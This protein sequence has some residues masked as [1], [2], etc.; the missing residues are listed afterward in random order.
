MTMPQKLS[1]GDWVNAGLKALAR[2]GFTAVKA[3]QIA[4]RLTVSRGSFYWHFADTAAFQKAVMQRWRDV[5]AESVIRDLE[6][7][8]TASER[9]PHLLRV[10]FD[11]DTA[12]EIAMRAWASSDTRARALVRSV[13]DRRLAYLER[14]L[15]DGGVAADHVR[16]RAQILYW[17]YL[18]FVLSAKPAKGIARERLIDQLAQ[19]GRGEAGPAANKSAV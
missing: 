10:A 2:D 9:L 19:L 6:S 13:D 18:G 15:K 4:K 16:P 3:D 14:I 7:L 5:A 17:T 1:T 11:A 12:L 8:S